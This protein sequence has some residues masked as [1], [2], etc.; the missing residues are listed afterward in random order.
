MP[1]CTPSRATLLTGQY[2]FRHGWIN[3]WDVPRW[4]A[5]KSLG[6]K[7]GDAYFDWKYHITFA[8]V[9]KSLGYATAAAGKWQIND[10]RVQP[11]AM[12]KHGF[13]EYAMWTGV[14]LKNPPSKKR[15]WEPYIHSNGSVRL[16]AGNMARMYLWISLSILWDAIRMN[17]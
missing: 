15:Y 1:K 10:F 13:D 4:S 2:P 3:H 5:P 7:G 11:D 8:R 17:P 9:M 16:I 6:G 12:V 14:E